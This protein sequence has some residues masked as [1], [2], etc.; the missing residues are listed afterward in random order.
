MT[1]Q[2][3]LGQISELVFEWREPRMLDEIGSSPGESFARL[4]E[5]TLERISEVVDEYT[6][7]A[8][9]FA[10]SKRSEG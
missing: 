4:S 5:S 6:R 10:R 7:T 9:V 3:A 8:P 1:A 2:D